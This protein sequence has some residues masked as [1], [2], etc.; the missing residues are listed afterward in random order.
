MLLLRILKDGSHSRGAGHVQ[1]FKIEPNLS[2]GMTSDV[3]VLF[4][5][6]TSINRKTVGHTTHYV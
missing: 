1:G 6:P 3:T 5:L 4:A 2:A